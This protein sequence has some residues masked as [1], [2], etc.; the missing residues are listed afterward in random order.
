MWRFTLIGSAG[1]ETQVDDPQGWEDLTV[2]LDRDDTWKGIFFGYLVD[3]L[4]FDGIGAM[5]IK[6]EYDTNGVSG[7]MQLLIE[8]LCGDPGVFAFFYQG[9]LSFVQYGDSCGDEC[10]VSIGIEDTGDIMLMRN[11]YQVDVNLN[12]SFAFDGETVLTDY[13]KLNFDLTIPSRGILQKST[14]SNTVLQSMSFL[15]YPGWG[16]ISGSGTGTEQGGLMPIFSETPLAEIENTSINTGPFYDSG[17]RF[18]DGTNSYPTQPFIDL[19]TNQSLKCAPQGVHMQMRLK[20]RLID[21]SNATR[22]VDLNSNIGVGPNAANVTNL[23]NQILATYEEGTFQTTE[24]DVSYDQIVSMNPG[25]KLYVYAIITYQKLSSAVIQQLVIEWD[26]ETFVSFTAT[27]YCDPTIV[28]SYMINEATSRTIEAITNGDIRFYSTY[29]GRIDSEPYAIGDNPCPGL[30]AVTNGLN[31]RRRLLAD[32]TQPGFFVNLKKI[33]DDLNAIYN[34]G[35]TIEPDQNRPAYNR[36]RFEDWRYFFQDDVGLVFNDATKINRDVDETRLFNRLTVGYNKWTAGQFTGLDEF[37]TKRKYRININAIDKELVMSTDMICSTYTIEITRRLDQTTQD[38]QYDSDI[39]GL[40]LNDNYQ[41]ALFT[42]PVYGSYGVSNVLDPDS[43]YNG[44][45]SPARSGEHWFSYVLQGIRTLGPNSRLIFTTGEGNYIAEYGIKLCGMEGAELSEGQDIEITTFE[46][47]T[48]A[49]PVIYPE[50]ITFD[51][52]L[53]WNV[54]TRILAEPNLK[55]KSIAVKCNGNITQAWLKTL[56]Y[57]P[58]AGMAKIVAIPKNNSI[59][60]APVPPE[61]CGATIVPGSITLTDFEYDGSEGVAKLDF[62]EGVPGATLWHFIVTQGSTPG[63]GPGISGN[64]TFHPI[65]IGGLSPGTWSAFIVPYCDVA[66][67]GANYA[68]GTFEL[69]APALKM[70]IDAKLI[71]TNKAQMTITPDTGITVTTAFSFKWGLCFVNTSSGLTY[72]HGFPGASPATP[73]TTVNYPI[74]G[75]SVISVSA[76]GTAGPSFGYI[77]K[78]VIF[79]MVGITAAEIS[80]ASLSSWPLEFM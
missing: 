23:D 56:E 9:N 28:K 60:P 40:C 10:L 58:N 24:F 69:P 30:F 70:L 32:N 26:P 55:Y 15:E 54:F 37:M 45:I 57:K 80:K 8:Y 21:N 73:E 4:Q 20:G 34:I 33:F 64:A 66:N 75:T 19:V 35:L 67:V 52:A 7:Q 42:D 3:K 48:D 78:I 14:G 49:K 2:T 13:A 5:L 41:V 18:N 11:N 22:I 25:D 16:D 39:F 68:E 29:F 46:D 65:T 79:D 38:W 59:I 31:M 71:S 1:T 74:G 62:T 44:R 47:I 36:L 77:Q 17:I 12:N 43:C 27:S 61:T 53:S 72:C 63:S 76:Q 50:T 6:D 51:H